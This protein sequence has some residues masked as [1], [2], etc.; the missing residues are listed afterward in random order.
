VRNTHATATISI[1]GAVA[2]AFALFANSSD[3]FPIAPGG[4]FVYADFAA[5]KT[6][7]ASTGDILRIA[8]SA[9]GGTYEL[10]IIG[11]K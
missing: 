11:T 3:I 10:I 8:S 7:A 4:V 5:G 2:N 1:G 6:V 9:N